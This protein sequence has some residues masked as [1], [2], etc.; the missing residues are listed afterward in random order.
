MNSI[1]AAADEKRDHTQCEIPGLHVCVSAEVYVS[2]L[3]GSSCQRRAMEFLRNLIS[4]F[5]EEK[6]RE[7]RPNDPTK[8]DTSCHTVVLSSSPSTIESQSALNFIVWPAK[9]SY[10][11][12]R[13]EKYPSEIKEE[14]KLERRDC[15][16][17]RK[18][19]CVDVYDDGT[20]TS[21]YLNCFLTQPVCVCVRRFIWEISIRLANK[22]R[23]E[24]HSND[25]LHHITST[26][27][28]LGESKNCG[29]RV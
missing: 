17:R 11:D 7:V 16:M 2:S 24:N 10:S 23:R 26:A 22:Q 1:Y 15:K 21:F 19:I 20:S 8:D 13:N 12:N 3:G 28:R 5:S 9:Q 18:K 4:S 14:T 6:S 29:K 27:R 25:A